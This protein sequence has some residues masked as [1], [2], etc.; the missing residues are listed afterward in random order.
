MKEKIILDTNKIDNVILS[1][2]GG[3]SINLYYEFN[4]IPVEVD[5]QFYIDKDGY[6][7]HSHLD[8]DGNEYLIKVLYFDE[9]N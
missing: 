9:N 2:N 4:G 3:Y 6:L 7:H 5:G 8:E 1:K